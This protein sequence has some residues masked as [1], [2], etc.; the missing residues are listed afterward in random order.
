VE[1]GRIAMTP[2]ESSSSEFPVR[3]LLVPCPA[4]ASPAF[5]RVSCRR[6][7]S[8]LFS[9]I[10]SLFGRCYVSHQRKNREFWLVGPRSPFSPF[11]CRSCGRR[12]LERGRFPLRLF[13]KRM[14]VSR[15]SHLYKMHISRNGRTQPVVELARPAMAQKQTSSSYR[16]DQL[17]PRNFNQPLQSISLI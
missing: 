5:M 10:N 14:A 15:K 13:S 7:S 1:I 3:S 4:E 8:L 2:A 6:K 12:V 9:L 17:A 16:S 11:Q